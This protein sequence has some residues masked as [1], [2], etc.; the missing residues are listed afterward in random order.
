M[1]RRRSPIAIDFG[2]HSV[3]ALQ[4][5]TRSGRVRVVAAAWERLAAGEPATREQRWLVAAAAA[6]RSA[7]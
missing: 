3:A 1:R 4:L 5:E 2:E 6:L 7:R